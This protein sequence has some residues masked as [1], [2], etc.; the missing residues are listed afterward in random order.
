MKARVSLC[1]C[2][3]S[4][5][6]LVPSY[7]KYR[8]RP[9]LRQLAP[10]RQHGQLMLALP[11]CD[12]YRN[13]TC[14]SNLNL[15]TLYITFNK[16]INYFFHLNTIIFKLMLLSKNNSDIWFNIWYTISYTHVTHMTIVTLQYI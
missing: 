3:D 13:L 1:K 15:S 12:K 9:E 10:L 14:W 5:E 16:I 11:I 4:P 2:V 8:C 6:P 7:T